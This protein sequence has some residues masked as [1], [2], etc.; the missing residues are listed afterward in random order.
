MSYSDETEADAYFAMKVNSDCWDAADSA[1]KIVAL[2]NATLIID[3]LGFCGAVTTEG[4]ANEFPRD[5]DTVVPEDIKRANSEIANALID[6]VDPDVEYENLKMISQGYANVRSTYDRNDAQPHVLAGV[7]SVVAWQYLM[8]YLIDPRT[9][10][11]N[12]V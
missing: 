12:R 8:P 10:V 5:G 1:D 3:R 2:N 6:G 11:L 4:Q 7:P 9:I